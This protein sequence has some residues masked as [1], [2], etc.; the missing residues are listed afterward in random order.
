MIMELVFFIIF[1]Y[2]LGSIPF[3]YII[4][5][6]KGINIQTVGSGNIGG[7]NVGRTLGRNYG[8]L[9]VVLDAL[10]GLIPVYLVQQQTHNEIYVSLVAVAVLLGHIYSLFLK[11]KGG[12]GIATGFGV[13]IVIAG[14][15]VMLV[16]V[17]IWAL[18]LYTTKIMSLSNLSVSLLIPLYFLF[19]HYSP[20]YLLL[21]SM[22][23]V[24]VWWSHRENIKRLLAGKEPKVGK[25]KEKS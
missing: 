19:I 10:K 6:A 25:K 13:L 11:F 15:Q 17:A 3:G 16:V 23:L 7:A 5:K 24:V 1:A 21:T 8:I 4:A 9:V 18:L 14:W 20:V 22:I 2:L 12:K